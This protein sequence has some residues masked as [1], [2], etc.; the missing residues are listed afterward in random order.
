MVAGPARPLTSSLRRFV[1]L[2]ISLLSLY[3]DSSVSLS[4]P[5]ADLVWSDLGL[6]AEQSIKRA[7]RVMR[8]RP[9]KKAKAE[10]LNIKALV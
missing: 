2:N 4:L 3:L 7:Q 5:F 8:T 9:G 10:I 1:A 6:R